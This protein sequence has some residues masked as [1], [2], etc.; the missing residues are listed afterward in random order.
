M[1]FRI[2]RDQSASFPRPGV[3]EPKGGMILAQ[4]QSNFFVRD[5]RCAGLIGSGIG[6]PKAAED[7][8]CGR[9]D[10]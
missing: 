5:G 9:N 8:L 3:A 10:L 1:A 4:R 6:L 2:S 7:L